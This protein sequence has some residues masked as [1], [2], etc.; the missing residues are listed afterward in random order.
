MGIFTDGVDSQRSLQWYDEEEEL[1]AIHLV[2]ILPPHLMTDL[3]RRADYVA[4]VLGTPLA[5][6]RPARL[7]GEGSSLVGQ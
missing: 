5:R 3:E 2:W 4:F 6:V 7:E 1:S